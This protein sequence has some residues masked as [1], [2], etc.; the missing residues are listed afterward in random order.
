[1][2]SWDKS[3][4]VASFVGSLVDAADFGEHRALGFHEHG[5]LIAGI[6]FHN[7]SEEHGTI[8]VSAGAT[9]PKWATRHNLNVAFG[10]AFDDCDCQLVIA[11]IHE[12]N[13]RARRLW[14]AFGSQEYI[15]PRLRG[16][17]ASEA[18]QTLSKEDWATSK[19]AR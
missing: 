11:R 4:A 17:T 19:F 6:V 8:E 10:Y 16:R 5:K 12:D 18:I 13:K 14:R 7:W 3:G 2:Y 1:M 15:I 9:S